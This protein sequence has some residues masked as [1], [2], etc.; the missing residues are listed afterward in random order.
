MVLVGAEE[1]VDGGVLVRRFLHAVEIVDV[2]LKLP[3]LVL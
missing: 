1:D 2:H 3:G